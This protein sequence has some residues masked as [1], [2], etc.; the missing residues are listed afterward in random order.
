MSSVIAPGAKEAKRAAREQQAQLE[1]QRQKESLRAAEAED[2][3]MRRKATAAKGGSRAS[4]LATSE[5]GV[6]AKPAKLGG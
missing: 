2:E 1:K 3:A 4:L 6:Q 5:T